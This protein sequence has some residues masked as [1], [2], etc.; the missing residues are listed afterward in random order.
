MASENPFAI[1]RQECESILAEA[2]KKTF[3]E[4]QITDLAFEKPPNPEYGQLASSACFELAKKVGKKPPDTAKILTKAIRKSKFNLIEHV[5]SAG[6]GYINFHTDF[7]KFSA[8]TIESA[9]QLDTDYGFVRTEK[10]LKIIVEH[11]STNP[12]HPI[13]IGA[14]RNPML[15][16]AVARM[17]KSRGNTVFRHFYIDDVGRQTAVIAYGYKKLGKPKPAEKPDRFIGKIY[18]IT[19]CIV[20]INRLKKGLDRA[21]TVSATEEIN[22]MNKEL[23]DWM[24][25][26]VELKGKH[27][28]FFEKLL[29]EIGEDE[30][31]QSEISK[32]NRAY[33]AEDEKAKKL[34]REV[35]ELCL[36]GLKETMSRADVFYDSWDWESDLVWSGKV[37]EALQ[38]LK[39]TPYVFPS[40]KVLEFDAEKAVR[41]LN[42]R[43][44]LGLREDY[45]VPPLT[46]VRADGTTLYTTRDVAYSLWKFER[47]D[48]LVNVIGMEQ[49]LA[50]LQLKIALHALGCGKFADNLVHFAY[51]LVSLPGYR[52][53]SRM[54]RYI[55]FDEVMDEAL[56]RAYEEVSKRSPQLSEGEKKS[57][58]NFVGIGAVRYALVEVD[59]SKPVVFTWDRVLN[60]EKNSAPYIQYT[61]ARAC[62]ILR[63]AARKPET[64]DYKLLNEKSEHGIILA[65]ASFPDAFVEASEFL[66]PNLI[67]DFANSLADKFNTFYNALP[68]IKAESEGL[69]DARLSLVDA[70]RIVLRNAL[71]LIGIVA[72]EK[73]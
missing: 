45:E 30:D 66:K 20:E 3:P 33:E 32:L 41:E 15:G 21:K 10:P 5:E 36:K 57:I 47:A 40:G 35:T 22:K 38:G 62:S 16:D 13:H 64:P 23:D 56:E 29:R 52:M 44:K 68:V 34:V 17:L 58:A 54:G 51:N 14:A 53:E 63:K 42:L 8:L 71:N 55:T 6:A 2:L 9:R 25:V 65:L 37:S 31:P 26:A 24:S 59:P 70:V 49:N 4:I 27:P 67:A 72:P 43:T 28:E 73:M 69:S 19:S 60:F 48:R 12:A 11:T 46:L 61:H 1:F 18:T 7:A 39:I 50:Q